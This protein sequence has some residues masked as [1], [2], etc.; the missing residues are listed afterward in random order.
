MSIVVLAFLSLFPIHPQ[1]TGADI[2]LE[3]VEVDV[4]AS[5]EAVKKATDFSEKDAAEGLKLSDPFLIEFYTEWRNHK[6]L[7]YDI[8]RWAIEILKHRFEKA[9]HLW[10]VVEKKVPPDFLLQAQ[11]THLYLMWKLDLPQTFLSHLL[12]MT[13]RKNVMNSKLMLALDQVIGKKASQWFLD[14]APFFTKEQRDRVLKTDS[15]K[16]VFFSTA[17]LWNLLRSGKKAIPYLSALSTDHPF[18]IHLAKTAV[19]DLAG[20]NSLGEAGRIMKSQMEPAVYQSGNPALL[21][22]YYLSLARLLYQ[23]GALDA[24]RVFYEK[25]PNS[26]P[27]FLAARTELLWVLLRKGD[28]ASLRGEMA[29]LGSGLF[30]N[31]FLPEIYLVRAISNLKL[32]QY[33]LVEKDFKDFIAVNRIFAK[34]IG[35]VLAMKDIPAPPKEDFFTKLAKVSL[36]EREREITRLDKLAKESIQAVL[37]AVGIQSHWNDAKKLVGTVHESVKKQL[38]GEYRRFWM[39][40]ETVL[41]EAIR[42]MKFV[43]VEVMTQMHAIAKKMDVYKKNQGDQVSTVQA[44]REKLAPD[45]LIF[46]FDGNLWPDE[47]FTMKSKART[48]CLEKMNSGS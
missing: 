7:P 31:R 36:V 46:P 43:K 40:R 12:K 44:S 48:Y 22:E 8:N 37:P 41:A 35:N 29:T 11:M 27:D 42:K 24:A 14:K 39:N 1:T 19:F 21:S 15:S 4:N 45:Q 32:C 10:S 33:D 23:A 2:L 5:K 16:N 26:V 9:A 20:K 13:N 38:K 34:E 25:I 3:N 30:S 18:K 17:K 28:V 47:L 6:G